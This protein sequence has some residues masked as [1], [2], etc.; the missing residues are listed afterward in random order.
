MTATQ[1][2]KKYGKLGDCSKVTFDIMLGYN[3]PKLIDTKLV[4]FDLQI[5]LGQNGEVKLANGIVWH[6]ETGWHCHAWIEDE[7][8]CY[9]Y[10][11]GL[12][13]IVEKDRY[14]RIGKIK[15]V[16]LYTRKQAMKLGFKTQVCGFWDMPKNIK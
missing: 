9:D 2:K 12:H 14:Y 8:F 4:P 15:D 3:P 5:M 10:S 11:N 1:F 7:R 6:E 16:K 13:C